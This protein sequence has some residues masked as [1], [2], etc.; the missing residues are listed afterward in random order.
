MCGIFG[1]VGKLNEGQIA[2]LKKQLHHRGPDDQRWKDYDDVSLF[3]AR[4]SIVDAVG[5][6]QPM[7]TERY[8][9]VF[10]GEIYNHLELR[11]RF[12]LNC[13]TRSDTET[14]LRLY[15]LKGEDM[16]EELDGMFAF[17]ILNKDDG[18]VFL[19]RDRAGEK[20]L[21]YFKDEQRWCFASEL[22]TLAGL[23]ALQINQS[24]VVQFLVTGFTGPAPTVYQNV[25]HLLP[26]EWMKIEKQNHQWRFYQRKWWSY[27][28][29]M[30]ASSVSYK[31]EELKEELFSLLKLSIKRRVESSDLP[32]GCFLS[33]GLDSSIVALLA[34]FIKAPLPTYT[35]VF[36]DEF[37]EGPTAAILAK[38]IRTQHK[39]L[40][41]NY[42]DIKQDIGKIL[43]SYGEPFC[44]DS[45]I[46][47]YYIAQEA[48]KFNTVIIN[49]DGG[50]ELFGGYRRYVPLHWPIAVKRSLSGLSKWSKTFLPTP[51]KKIH[52]YNYAY[53][54]AQLSSLSYPD[55]YFASTTDLFY[56]PQLLD[57]S[58]RADVMGA[59]E[60]IKTR[61]DEDELP[62]LKQFIAADFNGLLPNVLLKKVD[63]STMQHS[64]ESRT[65]FFMPEIMNLAAALPPSLLVSGS[66]TKVLLR[67]LAK[68]LL[69]EGMHKKPK[70]G[71]EAPLI[72][73][74]NNDLKEMMADYLLT[75]NKNGILHQLIP[76][77][78]IEDIWYKADEYSGDRR[79]K[80]LYTLF[81][82]EY[83]YCEG[84]AG[85]TN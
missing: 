83:W 59:K 54:L 61:F 63:I 39:E 37:N 13:K 14:L 16:L 5:G 6:A 19:A 7:E 51:R 67:L 85:Q 79:S 33:G 64:L 48:K 28:S 12:G 22:N 36:E 40:P 65:V 69:P 9:I 17:A 77:S 56:D 29:C 31:K 45:A 24:A 72:K 42:N 62:E 74:V 49:G 32:V 47:S 70:R 35:F 60:W 25:Y 43:L 23:H 4:L 18:S 21:Y 8:A 57:S 55:K 75:Q 1:Q 58:C 30:R 84:R 20:P 66:Q 50:D 38:R 81:C 26:G 34:S 76:A 82:L 27:E 10:N 73:L 78:A 15:E 3:H 68:K 53:R 11:T 44:D 46:P 80:L 52:L 41:V 2:F 71:F